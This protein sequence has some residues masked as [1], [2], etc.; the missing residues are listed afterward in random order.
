MCTFHRYP[1]AMTAPGGTSLD[2][3]MCRRH[4]LAMLATDAPARTRSPR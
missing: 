3:G 4:T 2:A 1:H